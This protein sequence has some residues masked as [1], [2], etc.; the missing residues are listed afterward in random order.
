MMPYFTDPV[1]LKEFTSFEEGVQIIEKNL[2]AKKGKT[3]KVYSLIFK[4][5][6][7]FFA[8]FRVKL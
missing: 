8:R 4:V 7:S 1:E 2:A 6:Y 3:E 5:L